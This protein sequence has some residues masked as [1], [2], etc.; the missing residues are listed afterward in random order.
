MFGIR[1]NGSPMR[2]IPALKGCFRAKSPPDSAIDVARFRQV[3]GRFATGVTVITAETHGEVR[4]MT[5]N[6]FMSGSLAP[7]LCVVSIARRARMY[8]TISAAGRFGVNM[9]AYGQSDVSAHFAGRPVASLQ[10]RFRTEAGVPILADACARIVAQTVAQHEC[11]DHALFI[12][13]ILHLEADDRP[14]LLVHAGHYASLM[15][16]SDHGDALS[17]EFW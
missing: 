4:G 15:Y 3:M 16:A 8:E 5:A 6:A 17:V 7:P 1:R 9:L 2:F 12:G 13:H 11:G 14:P 10:P